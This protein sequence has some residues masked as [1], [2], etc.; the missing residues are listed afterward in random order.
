MSTTITGTLVDR[1][2]QVWASASVKFEIQKNPNSNDRYTLGGSSF[3]TSPPP[4]LTD[5][6][7][8]F[9]I[10]LPANSEI[11]PD[12]STWVCTITPNA[13]YQA[14]ILTL[15]TITGNLDIS[16]LFAATASITVINSKF[17]PRAY[18]DAEVIVP[19]NSGQIYYNVIEKNLKYWENGVWNPLGT[20]GGSGGMI[21]PP[22]GIAV[23]AGNAWANS[24][25]PAT[26]VVYPAP[27]IPVS[28]GTSWG[29]P[30]D[31]AT[32]QK[33]LILTTVGNSGP[34]TFNGTTLNIPQYAGAVGGM[35]YP[36]A[37]ISISTG[38]AWSNSIPYNSNANGTWTSNVAGLNLIW[39]LTGGA[40]EL[41]FI[42]NY[43][44]GGG[45]GFKF[46]NVANGTVLASGTTAGMELDRNNALHVAND[47]ISATNLRC[48]GVGYLGSNLR[49][50]DRSLAIWAINSP[51]IN[52]DSVSLV[53][54]AGGNGSVWFNYEQGTGGVHFMKGDNTGNVAATIDNAGVIT[55]A[56]IHA[57]G[58]IEA[59][60]S[61][62]WLS[63]G[64]VSF[65]TAAGT[66]GQPMARLFLDVNG[67]SSVSYAGQ[68]VFT[69]WS[70]PT[71]DAA[72]W[73][74]DTMA[75]RHV[76]SGSG[77]ATGWLFQL[78]R[79]GG[80][81]TSG[82]LSTTGAHPGITG[83][84]NHSFQSDVAYLDCFGA[85]GNRGQFKF[86][87]ASTGAANLLDVLDMDTSG[88]TSINYSLT[89]GGDIV[90]AGN[91][92][93]IT[94]RNTQGSHGGCNI[95]SDVSNLFL[96]AT[97]VNGGPGGGIYFN[98]D[99][100]STGVHFGNGAAT[101]VAH[102]DGGGGANFSTLQL[103]GTAPL[104]Q[105]LT[106]NGSTYV[107]QVAPPYQFINAANF[108][109]SRSFGTVY[110]NNYGRPVYV[111]GAGHTTQGGTIGSMVCL[112]GG[113][114]PPTQVVFAQTSG[115]SITNGAI[116][117]FFVVPSG[118]FYRV[119]ANTLSQGSTAV[120]G[121]YAWNE[122]Y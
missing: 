91:T 96:N 107:P 109:G 53:L 35:V 87:I 99:R 113:G 90:C 22:V 86:R 21:F 81:T 118:W 15:K 89:V 69:T 66:A 115:A 36:P 62:S 29:V 85:G 1:Q 9:T 59:S 26:L 58:N 114:N 27:G 8:R 50:G 83:C 7:G 37:G 45:G 80:L 24:I 3:N 28:T 42:N 70:G 40:G 68:F 122:V 74:Q 30:I 38:T 23:S 88:N 79:N 64:P 93:S 76:T 120:T 106:G 43:G 54:N 52:A 101:E 4:V 13:T 49:L 71:P 98:W 32:L 5:S 72:G 39:N 102:I 12:N 51:N 34:S 82:G 60:L 108:T 73:N 56:T 6:G 110:Q 20:G 11:S 84:T 31:P 55:S 94:P 77:G 16:G 78:Q 65:A 44:A 117:F 19:P 119:D 17:V 33:N 61:N 100:G 97:N 104:G 2:G 121:V 111:S 48:T 105:V 10:V 95:N 57:G 75:I 67:Q 25:D 41:D 112:I 92:L 14:V 47:I 46:Y 103:N 116:G 63:A 18:T